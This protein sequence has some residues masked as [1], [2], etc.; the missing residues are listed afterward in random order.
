[1]LTSLSEDTSL[2]MGAWQMSDP[3]KQKL[4][5]YNAIFIFL[6]KPLH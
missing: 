5:T 2:S 4:F 6:C 3:A 1:M